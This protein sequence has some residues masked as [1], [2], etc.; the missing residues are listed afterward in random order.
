MSGYL[1]VRTLRGILIVS[2]SW[3]ICTPIFNYFYEFGQ[4]N[5]VNPL[6]LKVCWISWWYSPVMFIVGTIIWYFLEIQRK[7][8]VSRPI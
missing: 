2:M 4:L 8:E 7:E 6:L 5:G 1:F 3:F